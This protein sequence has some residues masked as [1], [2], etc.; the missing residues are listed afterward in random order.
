MTGYSRF[1]LFGAAALV[2]A[3]QSGEALLRNRI[4]AGHTAQYCRPDACYNPHILASEAGYY[5]TTFKAKTPIRE[6][7][8]A[9]QLRRF[10]L[11]LPM[12]AWPRGPEILMSP[13]D[14]VTDGLAVQRNLQKAQSLCEQ[15]GLVVNIRP[16]G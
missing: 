3:C 5:V 8:S 13:E 9:A 15:L 2:A 10:L 4:V 7:V 6:R 1:V 11:R 16:G 14:D 12:S